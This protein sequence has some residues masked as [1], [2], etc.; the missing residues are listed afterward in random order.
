[1]IILISKCMLI[2][3]TTQSVLHDWSDD[4]CIHILKNCRESIPK[5]KGKVVLLEV[6]LETD[7]RKVDNNNNNKLKDLGLF[8]DM[9]MM[10][11]TT[12][13]K[14]RTLDEW[15]YV[16]SEAGFGRPTVRS[17]AAVQ[18]VIEAFPA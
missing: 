11:H 9:V 4:E 13:G 3:N 8:L 10:A 5:D 17:I 2:C 14:E 1:M 18:S 6:V 15:T 12:T 16:L 7:E